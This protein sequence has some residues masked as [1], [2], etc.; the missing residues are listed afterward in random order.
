MRAQLNGSTSASSALR[1]TRASQSPIAQ[2]LLQAH[3]LMKWV[4]KASPSTDSAASS[5]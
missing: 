5:T 4:V 3:W 1:P 2:A